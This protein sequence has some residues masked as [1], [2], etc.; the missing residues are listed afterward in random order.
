[1]NAFAHD[2]RSE[3]GKTL[4]RRALLQ[5]SGAGIAANA[6]NREN[7]ERFISF[8]LSETGQRAYAE[9][10]HEFPAVDGAPFDND[11]L[12]AMADYQ[13]DTL[14]MSE[15]GENAETARRVFDRVGWP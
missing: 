11:T 4:T 9:L 3:P 8:L 7:A 13:A 10:T 6:P 2:L 12:R 5:G 14:N 15:L 1:M